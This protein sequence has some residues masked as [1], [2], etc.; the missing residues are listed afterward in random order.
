MRLPRI[1]ITMGDP[2][3]VGPE[4]CLKL[5]AD[6]R[7]R[8]FCEPVIVG[9][10]AVLCRVASLLRLDAPK[11]QFEVSE[12]AHFGGGCHDPYVISLNAIDATTVQPGIVAPACG[13]AAY[14]YFTF[15]ID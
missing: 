10:Y 7:V 3:G 13:S 8:E 5:L 4:L 11:Y 1:A 2:A 12:W 15:A 14:H 6:E 9:D